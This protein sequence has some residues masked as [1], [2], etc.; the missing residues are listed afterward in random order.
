MINAPCYKCTDRCD[1]CHSRCERYAKYK[2]ALADL[3]EKI[4]KDKEG[5]VHAPVFL[6]KMEAF[7]RAHNELI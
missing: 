2:E 7:K 1:N 5:N 3:N 6:K 4:Q